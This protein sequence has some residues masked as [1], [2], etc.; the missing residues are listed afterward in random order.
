MTLEQAAVVMLMAALMV[1]FALDVFRIELV[2]FGG[3]AAGT[4]LENEA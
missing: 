1:M 4:G 2:A 3:L